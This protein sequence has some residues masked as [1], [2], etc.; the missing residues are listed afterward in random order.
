MTCTLIRKV[1]I[2]EREL[3]TLRHHCLVK[4]EYGN[5]SLYDSVEWRPIT[6]QDLLLEILKGKEVNLTWIKKY[7]RQH[8]N[9]M[10]DRRYEWWDY[11]IIDDTVMVRPA[12]G[13]TTYYEPFGWAI[14]K[15]ELD[16]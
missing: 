3:K 8:T 2:R 7:V 13:G 11:T 12:S 4:S 5:K 14:L 10:Y 6:T 16:K 15:K 1:L 9:S